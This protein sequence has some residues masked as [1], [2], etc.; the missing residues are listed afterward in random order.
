MC[1]S[2]RPEALVVEPAVTDRMFLVSTLTSA[3]LTVIST[4][5]FSRA[6][7]YVTSEPPAVLVTAVR[8]GAYNGLHLALLARS[9]RPEISMV[10]TSCVPDRVLERDAH[11]LGAVFSLK[12]MT[13]EELFA[14]LYR[15]ALRETHGRLV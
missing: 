14:A 4:D 1:V 2:S 7:A 15:A 13:K 6:R 9:M 8:L 11:A 5:S 12:P 3:G 10:V